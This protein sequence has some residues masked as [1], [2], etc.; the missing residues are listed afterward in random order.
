MSSTDLA[1]EIAQEETEDAIETVE[2]AAD[3]LVNAVLQLQ[4]ADLDHAENAELADAMAAVRDAENS[5]EE[6]R[7]DVL[8][9]EVQDRVG[10]GGSVESDSVSVTVV[11]GHN[12]YLPDD[13]AAIEALEAAGIDPSTVMDVNASSVAKEAEN[14]GLDV[15]GIV[16]RATYTYPRIRQI[17]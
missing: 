4:E 15:D 12:K 17:D 6:A 3:K 16:G 7:K 9:Q 5:A 8:G 11:E 13:D 1:A 10:T 14:A 2:N